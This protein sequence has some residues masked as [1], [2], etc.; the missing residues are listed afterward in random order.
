[1]QPTLFIDRDVT[2]IDEP[3]TKL[4]KKYIDKNLFDPDLSFVIGDRTT[5]V[6]LAEN[7]GIRALQYDPQKLNWD[8]IVE[9]YSVKP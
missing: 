3:K 2:L 4:L 9:N 1:M 8:L 7:L 6:Q 5:D